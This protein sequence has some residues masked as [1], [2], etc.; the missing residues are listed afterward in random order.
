VTLAHAAADT[1]ERL[2]LPQLQTMM[3]ELGREIATAG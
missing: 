1:F 2:E 3:L